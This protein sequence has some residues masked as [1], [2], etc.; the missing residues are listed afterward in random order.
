MKKIL[1]SLIFV[2]GCTKS[3]QVPSTKYTDMVVSEYETVKSIAVD[4]KIGVDVILKAN[5]EIDID[6]KFKTGMRI[7]F[8]NGTG[9]TQFTISSPYETKEIEMRFILPKN[10]PYTGPLYPVP[11]GYKPMQKIIIAFPA[12]DVGEGLVSQTTI[13]F[14]LGRA[15]DNKWYIVRNSYCVDPIGIE[16]EGTKDAYSLAVECLIQN[17]LYS[18]L[19]FT[20]FNGI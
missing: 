16:A 20:L 4:L 15:S 6:T 5:P 8:P 17:R 10:I 2:L 1:I 3:A 19:E 9:L 14:D 7:K 11:S 12:K 18:W 13:S